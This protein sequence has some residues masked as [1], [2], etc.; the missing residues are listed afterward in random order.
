MG[1]IR[2]LLYKT[3][4]Y[5]FKATTINKQ[6]KPHQTNSYINIKRLASRQVVKYIEVINIF[7]NPD[8]KVFIIGN[9]R[10]ILE[11]KYDIIILLNQNLLIAN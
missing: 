3:T 2:L 1:E 10:L 11:T 9:Y 8:N 4:I 7:C 5:S 6:S